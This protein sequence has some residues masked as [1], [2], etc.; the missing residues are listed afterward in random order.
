VLLHG[1]GAPADD[2][3]G[4]EQGLKVPPGTR[5]VYP[6]ALLELD[7]VA[8]GFP[9]GMGE[10]RAWWPLDM[11][12]LQTRLQ[13]GDSTV[14]TGAAPSGLDA[15][16]RAVESLL[17]ELCTRADVDPERIVLGGFSQ[18]AIVS[19]HV[20]LR[21]PDRLA[22]LVLLSCA[23]VDLAAIDANAHRLVDLAVLQSHG[24]Q[25]PVLPYALAEL[26]KGR[27]EQA[28]TVLTWV[29]FDGGHGISQTVSRALG[30]FLEEA[31]EV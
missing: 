21:N 8:L 27:L 23:P 24:R 31:L 17:D 22:G 1:Y 2:L 12:Q 4:V 15:A 29:P 28:G 18:G 10:S 19:L 16:C 13:S 25:D 30:E 20:A 3:L 6:A 26:L 7:T 5:F 11:Y 14:L 9:P